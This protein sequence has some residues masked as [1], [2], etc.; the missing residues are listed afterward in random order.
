MRKLLTRE[1]DCGGGGLR[2]REANKRAAKGRAPV[3]V[4]TVYEEKRAPTCMYMHA[5]AFG[6]MMVDRSPVERHTEL[7]KVAGAS[8]S[9]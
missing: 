2:A 3:L 5:A 1:Q 8:V 4:F 7:G 9:S 6:S